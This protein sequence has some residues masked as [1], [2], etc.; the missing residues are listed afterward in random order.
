M[1][2]LFLDEPYADTLLALGISAAFGVELN[3]RGMS[4]E[5]SSQGEEPIEFPFTALE[6]DS[7]D[8]PFTYHRFKDF[9]ISQFG[10]R[11]L[12]Q[13]LSSLWNEYQPSYEEICNLVMPAPSMTDW[14]K[15]RFHKG[16]YVGAATFR[17]LNM[18]GYNSTKADGLGTAVGIS[19]IWLLDALRAIGFLTYAQ[20]KLLDREAPTSRWLVFVPVVP[21]ERFSAMMLHQRD[22]ESSVRTQVLAHCIASECKIPLLRVAKYAELHKQART[23]FGIFSLQ[24]NKLSENALKNIVSIN[25][26]ISM[27]QLADASQLAEDLLAILDNHDVEAIGRVSRQLAEYRMSPRFHSQIMPLFDTQTID[28]LMTCDFLINANASK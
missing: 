22:L 21:D 17:P 19:E 18:K 1:P 7:L 5:F 3:W 26:A 23:V 13:G 16:G 8:V 27:L 12:L 24:T 6:G 11:D 28:E 15:T 9:A 25:S 4:Y 10:G 20:P 14:K 2:N